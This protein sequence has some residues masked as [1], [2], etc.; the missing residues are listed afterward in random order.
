[1]TQLDEVFKRL[2]HPD[3]VGRAHDVDRRRGQ[4]PADADD[5]YRL[6]QLDKASRRDLRT[7]Q[8]ESLTAEVEQRL[9]RP[10]LVPGTSER[11]EDEVVP[12]VLGGIVDVLDQVGV[13]RVV[14]VHHDPEQVAPAASQQARGAVG[15]VPELGSR[16]KHPLTSLR[17]GTCDI[18]QDQGHRGC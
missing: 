13:V 12:M 6:V 1:M 9:H 3:V 8:D 17:T 11:A 7:E 10:T 4:P 5:R 14:H 18:A 2:G 16:I 15:A